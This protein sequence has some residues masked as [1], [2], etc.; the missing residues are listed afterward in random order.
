MRHV[1]LGHED[2]QLVVRQQPALVALEEH[3]L[4]K[5]LA[6]ERGRGH[7]RLL[8]AVV[9]VELHRRPP[10]VGRVVPLGREPLRQG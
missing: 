9:P 8:A 1:A 6:V 7:A 5:L 2:A 4:E 3:A 10:V